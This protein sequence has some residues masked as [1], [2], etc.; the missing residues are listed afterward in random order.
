M[1]LCDKCCDEKGSGVLCRLCNEKLNTEIG[2]P[3]YKWR[4]I[5]H[6]EIR[7]YDDAAYNI[8]NELPSRFVEAEERHDSI[9]L[10][11]EDI[12]AL[13]WRFIYEELS[14]MQRQRLLMFY[15]M[16]MTQGQI[17]KFYGVK[18]S[19]IHESIE[20]AINKIRKCFSI[21]DL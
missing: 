9:Y 13:L 6:S 14:G 15:F 10:N 21:I 12:T 20:L 3:E 4:Q 19:S 8:I 5:Q 2:F 7:F 16:G 17:A 1:Q 11:R 18:Q